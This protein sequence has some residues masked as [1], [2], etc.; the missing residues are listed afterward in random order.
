[1]GHL[2]ISTMT[3]ARRVAATGVLALAISAVDAS[4]A[5]IVQTVILGPISG[6]SSTSIDSTFNE[7]NPVDGTLDSVQLSVY[8]TLDYLV[9]FQG[10]S[11]DV[12]VLVRVLRVR[13]WALRVRSVRGL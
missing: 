5:Q 7:F 13:K 2:M 10:I 1:M 6:T 12:F 4:A 11:P 3:Y 9:T 8:S